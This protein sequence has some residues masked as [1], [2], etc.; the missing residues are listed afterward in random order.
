MAPEMQTK[1]TKKQ[2]LQKQK[3]RCRNI[4]VNTGKLDFWKGWKLQSLER[5][6]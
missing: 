1:L 2:L 5:R 6:W 4:N 3:D